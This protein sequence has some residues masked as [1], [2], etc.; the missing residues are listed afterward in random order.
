MTIPERLKVPEIFE[1]E[2]REYTEICNSIENGIHTDQDISALLQKWNNRSCLQYEPH[3]F[4]TYY[5]S[6]STE[7]FVR[8]A[9]LPV[10]C[11]I[12]DLTYSELIT[13]LQAVLSAEFRE[14]EHSYY[15]NLLEEN[16]PGSNIIDLIYWPDQWF[17]DS[18]QLHLELTPDQ[19]A[20][21]AMLKSG[22]KIEGAP[23]DIELPLPVPKKSVIYL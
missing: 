9:L 1:E 22:R 21:Y 12:D 20:A 13:V 16:L 14:S 3:E 10:A 5:G 4:T 2:I 6:V 11:R 18:N 8:E 19:I 23:N 15:L 7:E 17:N